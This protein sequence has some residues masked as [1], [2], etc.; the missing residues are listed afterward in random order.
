M[1]SYFYFL[2]IF[3]SK[4]CDQKFVCLVAVRGRNKE[5]VKSYSNFFPR[6]FGMQLVIADTLF[7]VEKI[8]FNACGSVKSS[9]VDIILL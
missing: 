3:L 6:W 5:V 9:L 2:S 1:C 4:I 7:R 8:L